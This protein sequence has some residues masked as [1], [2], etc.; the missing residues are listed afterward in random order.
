MRK[1]FFIAGQRFWQVLR[2]WGYWVGL[3]TPVVTLAIMAL[4]MGGVLSWAGQSRSAG[5]RTG[6]NQSA[7]DTSPGLPGIVS[8]PFAQP[9]G[10]VDEAGLLKRLPPGLPPGRL[11]R[12]D[13][14]AQAKAAARAGQIAGFYVV[15]ADY[16]GGGSAAYYA[17][18]LTLYAGTDQVFQDILVANLAQASDAAVAW[19]VVTPAV[20]TYRHSAQAPER[21]PGAFDISQLS[22]G[23]A[24]VAV[25]F[26]ITQSTGRYSL[27]IMVGDREHGMLEILLTSVSAGQFLLGKLLSAL[28]F[29]GLET[30]VPLL[31]LAGLDGVWSSARLAL[32]QSNALL[33]PLA[34]RAVPLP[35]GWL[36]FTLGMIAG[37]VLAY[38]ALL[39][40]AGVLIRT[41]EGVAAAD[42]AANL[43]W[44]LPALGLLA[45]SF[46]S[47]GTT[48]VALSVIPLTSA[49]FMPVRLLSGPVP[50][51]QTALSIALLPAMIALS[52]AL[53]AALFRARQ[54]GAGLV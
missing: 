52:L 1:I 26:L 25:L 8:A 45:M 54:R 18:T 32:L 7:G 31:L 12:Y 20:V 19:R 38:S 13:T 37:T 2:D 30:A 41:A 28:L 43:M 24:I 40:M 47:P 34:L 5:N 36:W 11:I 16:L 17:D 14:Q 22:A 42:N 44:V 3:L 9:V 53:A 39:A 49:V 27:S 4:A 35:A 6:Q 23:L 48:A 29:V 50:I 33:A 15:P 10:Y 46:A 21:F 51:W